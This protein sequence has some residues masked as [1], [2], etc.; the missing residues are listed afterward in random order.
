MDRSRAGMYTCVIMQGLNELS[1]NVTVTVQCKSLHVQ[2][3]M[4][5]M[6]SSWTSTMSAVAVRVCVALV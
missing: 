3:V 2:C 6:Q 4:L 1:A 5:H